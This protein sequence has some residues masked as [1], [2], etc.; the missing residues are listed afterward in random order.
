ME[1]YNTFCYRRS[2]L[3]QAIILNNY[4]ITNY[5]IS[6]GANVNY[7][8]KTSE[9]SYTSP[10]IEAV[11]NNNFELVKLL[12]SNNAKI[13]NRGVSVY[14]YTTDRTDKRIIELLDSKK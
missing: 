4:E 9:N 7:I 10:L 2:P 12:L 3:L 8:Q 13:E 6:I 11:C 14:E 5:L 1:K